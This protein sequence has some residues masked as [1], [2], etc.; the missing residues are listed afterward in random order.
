MP[1][2]SPSPSS[3]PDPS[4]PAPCPRVLAWL[5]DGLLTIAVGAAALLHGIEP[6]IDVV[7]QPLSFYVHGTKGWLL[8]LA[9]AAFGSAAV[10]LGF[11][12]HSAPADSRAARWLIPFG[13]GMIVAALVPSD[14]WF[15]W[16]GPVSVGGAIHALVAVVAPP[17][18]LG[19]MWL[20]RRR[21]NASQLAQAGLNVLAIFYLAG[22]V[23]SALSLGIGFLS[24]RAPPWI[25]LA[26]RLLALAAVAWLAVAA[27]MGG[28]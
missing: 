6:A 1:G 11:R 5:A 21:S 17:L 3:P 20:L 28:R 10:A 7:Q 22:L 2:I 12:F 18:L 16:E 27:R 26:E 13:L 25:G 8:P 24:D 9:L 23:A 14:R 19:A 15:P 4:A